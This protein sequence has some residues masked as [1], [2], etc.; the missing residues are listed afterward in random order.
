MCISFVV[1]KEEE[2]ISSLSFITAF[3]ARLL[4]MKSNLVIISPS[5]DEN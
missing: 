5:E 3:F 2:K 4:E 1:F